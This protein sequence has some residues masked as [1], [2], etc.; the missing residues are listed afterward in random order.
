MIESNEYINVEEGLGRIQ[1]NKMLYRRI[2]SIFLTS[3]SFDRLDQKVREG[4]FQKASEV[5]HEIKGMTGNLALPLLYNESADLML[6]LREGYYDS[7]RYERYKI[8]WVKTKE[9]VQ[10]V[11]EGLE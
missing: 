10:H 3:D 1:G 6:H 5:A 7:E 11:F 9:A 4:D 8:T 2:L